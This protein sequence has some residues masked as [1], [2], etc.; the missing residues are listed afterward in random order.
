MGERADRSSIE[1]HR[2]AV[3][4]AL[5]RELGTGVVMF[6]GTYYIPKT[7]TLIDDSVAINMLANPQLMDKLKAKIR[8]ASV[9]RSAQA[10]SR[11][12]GAAD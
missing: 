1:M 7:G 3:L 6:D 8:K 9:S 5:V 4:E 10:C 2:L 12:H 11:L